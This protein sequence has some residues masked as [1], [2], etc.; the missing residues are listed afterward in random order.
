MSGQS[1]GTGEDPTPSGP[2]T[3]LTI[4]AGIE[5]RIKEMRAEIVALHRTARLTDER[6]AR[7]EANTVGLPD[8]LRKLHEL[9]QG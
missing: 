1:N 3:A 6:V 8:L 4:L 2:I 7:V 9:E 5:A